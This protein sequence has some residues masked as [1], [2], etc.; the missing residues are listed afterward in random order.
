MEMVMPVSKKRQYLMAGIRT[1][2]LVTA[3]TTSL[4]VSRDSREM[5]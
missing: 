1:R 5:L 4:N 2:L 3:S